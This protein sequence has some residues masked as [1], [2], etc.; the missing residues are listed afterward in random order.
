MQNASVQHRRLL[1]LAH[2]PRLTR[3]GG[4]RANAAAPNMIQDDDLVPISPHKMMIWFQLAS[5]RED[6]PLCGARGEAPV[7]PPRAARLAAA[8]AGA[9]PLGAALGG[10]PIPGYWDTG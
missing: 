9:P 2:N 8:V 1:R 4:S 3:V 6:A 7:E 5:G 10:L